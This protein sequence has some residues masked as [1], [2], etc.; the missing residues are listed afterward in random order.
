[1]APTKKVTKTSN[2]NESVVFENND[3]NT[4]SSSKNLSSSLSNSFTTTQSVPS[5]QS[6]QS[7]SAQSVSSGDC[8]RLQLAKAINNITAFGLSFK[9]SLDSLH[10]FSHQR[11]SDLDLKIETKKRE[12]VDLNNN[13]VN[14]FKSNQIKTEQELNEFQLKACEKMAS[15]YNMSVV[16]NEEL[17]KLK[18]DCNKLL[19][20]YNVSEETFN[21][22]LNSELEKE[23]QLY[24]AKLKQETVTL[25][26]RHK[27]ESAEIKA[28]CDQQKREIDVL[29][30][31]ITN[32]KH[33]IAEQRQL[34]KEVAIASSKSSINQS[35]SKDR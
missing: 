31:T 23:R 13:L 11:L 17:T 32:L 9:N 1:M 12:Y 8:D 16:K 25:E 2:K 33:E 26:L 27:M 18:A 34:T 6:T 10:E 14:D 19:H 22:R 15:K 30:H 24:F 29:N 28:Q 7:Y 20:D 21:T 4:L 35:F 3:D 5:A